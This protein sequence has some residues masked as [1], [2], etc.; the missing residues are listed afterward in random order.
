VV[1]HKFSTG[2]RY[3]EDKEGRTSGALGWIWLL[4]LALLFVLFASWAQLNQVQRSVPY[5]E[6]LSQVDQ[7]NVSDVAIGDDKI[8]GSF[9]NSQPGNPKQF[10]TIRVEDPALIQRLQ[11]TG[12]R[13]SGVHESRFLGTLLAWLIPLAII[14]FGLSFIAR[15]AG[16]SQ[17]GNP[18]LPMSKSRAKIYMETDLKVRFDDVAGVD[19]AKAELREI[20][21]FLKNPGRYTQL[22][23][24][25][26]KG[27]LLV[28]PPGTGK[29][30]LARAVAGEANVPFFSINGSEFVELFVGLGAARVRDLFQQARSKAPCIVFIDELDAL[31]KARG[32]NV[33]SGSANDEKEQTLNQLLAEMDGFDPSRGIILLAATNRPEVLD[34]ALLRAGRFDRQILVDK[35]DKAGREKILSI[36]LRNVKLAPGT[37]LSQI[38]GMTAGFSGADLANLANEAALIAT[39]RGAKLVELHDLTEAIERLV[40]GLERKSRILSPEEKRRV[41]FHEMGHA[42]VSLQLGGGEVVHKVSVIPRGISAIG[43]TLRRPKEDRYLMSR[44]ELEDKIAVALGGRAAESI[45]F[46]D[47]TTGAGD[48]LDKAT[49]IAKAMVTHYGMDQ[50]LG[51]GV[52]ERDPNRMLGTG[53]SVRT[54]DYS[55]KTAQLID[56]GMKAILD[57][58]MTTATAIINDNHELIKRAV[59]ILIEHETIDENE[60]LTL[61]NERNKPVAQAA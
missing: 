13:F 45:F 2:G 10:T 58:G 6:F 17:R 19:E 37:D 59:K 48:D 42:V 24:H 60:L 33:I 27:V 18:F 35:P 3:L 51:L 55:E 7:G 46:D 30:L 16:S 50:G 38:A 53:T 44:Q 9:K 29:T 15:R 12:V 5:S 4:M 26:P 43:Y 23:G 20:V 34:P 14:W 54:F 52:F 11:R 61:W 32:I 41:A 36:H 49:E 25:M 40:A 56:Q 57:R 1:L 31:G 39:R 22:G 8:T 47:I 21:D 28:G